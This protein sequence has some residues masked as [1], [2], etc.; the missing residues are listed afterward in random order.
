MRRHIPLLPLLGMAVLALATALQSRPA[1]A[2]SLDSDLV[3]MLRQPGY[4]ALMRHSLAPGSG[5]PANFDLSD[6]STQRNLSDEGRAQ[7]RAAGEMLREAGLT[8]VRVFTG[9]W[10]RNRE[11]A[12]LLGF[13][14][15]EIAPAFDSQMNLGSGQVGAARL[16]LTELEAERPVIIVTHS[17]NI[18]GLIGRAA[19]SGEMWVVRTEG[20][21]VE[22]VGS[23]GVLGE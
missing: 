12:E 1:I 2:Q 22:P 14:D 5:D 6:C 16:F 21:R 3:A 9:Q 8:E 17:S 19:T 10:C 18:R 13:G 15:V 11:T 7:A 20:S 23:L 4:V